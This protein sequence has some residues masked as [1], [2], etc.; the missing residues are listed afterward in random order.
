MLTTGIKLLDFSNNAVFVKTL[1]MHG[2]SEGQYLGSL[3]GPHNTAS[4]SITH[5]SH[6]VCSVGEMRKYR[7]SNSNIKQ[8]QESFGGYSLF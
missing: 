3:C 8:E 2:Q 6:A 4:H 1:S 5:G 7:V